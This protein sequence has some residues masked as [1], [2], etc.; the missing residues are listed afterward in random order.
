MSDVGLGVLRLSRSLFSLDVELRGQDVHEND[1]TIQC[2]ACCCS[3]SLTSLSIGEPAIG[4]H[5]A[6]PKVLTG[7]ANTP[8]CGA[9]H[10]Q[11]CQR[12]TRSCEERRQRHDESQHRRL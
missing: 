7:R 2:S 10:G 6:L 5:A 12:N 3:R 11:T 9:D 1:V 4:T 8:R